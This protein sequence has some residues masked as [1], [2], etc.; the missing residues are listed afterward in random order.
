VAIEHR[1]VGEGF[2]RW[3]AEAEHEKAQLLLQ[4]PV[5]LASRPDVGH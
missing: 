2:L 4:S 5:N 1:A 3:F